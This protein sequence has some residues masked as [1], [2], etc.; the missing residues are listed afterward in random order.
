MP[1]GV[2][3]TGDAKGTDLLALLS[4][5]GSQCLDWLVLSHGTQWDVRAWNFCHR[6]EF[7]GMT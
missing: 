5:A 2:L 4:F 7:E 1:D 6:T 3:D